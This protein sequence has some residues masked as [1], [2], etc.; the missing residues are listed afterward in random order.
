MLG[1]KVKDAN[2]GKVLSES[3]EEVLCYDMSR[4]RAIL[5]IKSMSQWAQIDTISQNLNI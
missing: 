4:W 1:V 2:G 3:V 5:V